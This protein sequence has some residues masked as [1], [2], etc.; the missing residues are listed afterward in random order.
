[1]TIQLIVIPAGACGAAA[2][3]AS[4]W[5]TTPQDAVA[6]ELYGGIYPVRLPAIAHGTGWI[7]VY[8]AE[9]AGSGFSHHS[10]PSLSNTAMRSSIGT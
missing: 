2:P 8:A 10:V 6:G 3:E 7:E 5:H 9:L 4:G 1:M